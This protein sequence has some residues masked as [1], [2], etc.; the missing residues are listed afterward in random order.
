MCFAHE[1]MQ[2]SHVNY[3]V[4]LAPSILRDF[5]RLVAHDSVG[6]TKRVV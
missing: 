6:V 2:L 1:H 4:K 5:K 3:D